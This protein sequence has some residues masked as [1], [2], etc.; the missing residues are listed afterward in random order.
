MLQQKADTNL[1]AKLDR[2][3]YSEEQLIEIRVPLNMPYQTGY[4]EFERVDGEVIV[5]GVHY[6]YVKRK[7]EDGQLVLKCIPNE[8]KQRIL[9]ARDEFFK[10]VNDLE[11]GA[12]KSSPQTSIAKNIIGD[13]LPMIQ[14]TL[15]VQFT[16][17]ENNWFLQNS[18]TPT[19]IWHSTPEQPP[20][21]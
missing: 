19:A 9:N 5:D 14:T 17:S 16:T 21:A 15:T 2:N 1:E 13:Y 18:G 12:K 4:N 10:L 8:T 20:N 11:N 7:I 3:Q 6:K